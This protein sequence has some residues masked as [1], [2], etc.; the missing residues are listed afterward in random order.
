MSPSADLITQAAVAYHASNYTEWRLDLE[1]VASK[2]DAAQYVPVKTNAEDLK[3][4]TST[5]TT[6]TTTTRPRQKLRPVPNVGG[7][8]AEVGSFVKLEHA[9]ASLP[10]ST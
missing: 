10:S 4:A 6:T 8:L 5:A 3:K 2:A 7:L 9:C 1:E